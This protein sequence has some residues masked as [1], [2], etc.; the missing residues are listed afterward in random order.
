MKFML[1]AAKYMEAEPSAP[2][3]GNP[4]PAPA[5]P[6]PADPA[7]A[8]PAPAPAP[9]APAPAPEAYTFAQVDG[10]D[11][12]PELVKEV[13]EF[14]KA[15][16]L[17]QAQ[18]QAIMDREYALAK[19]GQSD[20]QAAVAKQQQDWQN[21]LRADA[22][23]GGDKLQENLGVAKRALEKFFPDIAKVAST[24]PFLD[25]PDVVRGL[26]NIGKLITAD[27]DF[28]GGQRNPSPNDAALAMYPTMKS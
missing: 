18:A 2:L 5:D 16:G 11:A 17:N 15:N 13:S 6:A 28:V 26:V 20:H 23:I 9:A 10:A 12:D 24:M 8:D 25:N 14:A 22:E 27:G 21:A 19:G 1:Q 3:L 7:P 4:D